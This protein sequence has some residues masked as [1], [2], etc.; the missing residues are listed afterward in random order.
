MPTG[1]LTVDRHEEGGNLRVV[2]QHIPLGDLMITMTAAMST[3]G[4]RSRSTR[5]Y[6]GLIALALQPSV[7]GRYAIDPK[8]GDV[9]EAATVIDV[10]RVWGGILATTDL[11]SPRR[12]A[13][14][15]ASSGTPA[16]ASTPTSCPQAWWDLYGDCHRGRRR[17]ATCRPRPVPGTARPLRPGVDEGRRGVD[18]TPAGSFP[19]PPTFVPRAGA[20][21]VPTTATSSWS[22]TRTAPRS[23]RSSTPCTS[24]PARSRVATAPGFNPDLLLH[25]CWMPDRVG[26]RPSSYRI[27]CS[28]DV[29]GAVT[30]I[31]GVVAEMFRVGK[32]AARAAKHG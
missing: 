18:A 12:H 31:P 28:R 25:S 2:L 21:E 29:K 17:P 13:P 4:R 22:S 26:P 5:D 3:T 19:S 15:S 16:S 14:T 9:H 27:P 7:I 32:A 10:E 8:T 11:D 1:H 30:A 23:S 6:E 20:T 24:R